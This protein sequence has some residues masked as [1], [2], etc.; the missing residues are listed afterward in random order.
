MEKEEKTAKTQNHPTGAGQAPG[1]DSLG[2]RQRKDK[3]K[4]FYRK[5]TLQ[6]S[7]TTAKVL[8]YR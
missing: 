5:A 6:K 8:V 4:R 1:Q 2:R 3:R 7:S